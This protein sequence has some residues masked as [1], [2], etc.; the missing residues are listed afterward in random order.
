MYKLMIKIKIEQND[1]KIIN[2]KMWKINIL[3]KLIVKM[4][5]MKKFDKRKG[6]PRLMK[7]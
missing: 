2:M 7:R 4:Y 1:K 3:M 6:D 5:R